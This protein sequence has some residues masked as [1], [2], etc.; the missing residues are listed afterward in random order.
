MNAMR[1]L[2][3][4]LI[5][6]FILFFLAVP[7]PEI[8]RNIK[9]LENIDLPW[10]IKVQEDQSTEV[11]KLKPGIS[12]LADAIARFHEPEEIAIYAGKQK[13]SLEAYL[14]TVN[15]GPLQAKMILTLAATDDELQTILERTPGLSL[16]SSG[17]KKLRLANEDIQ[18]ALQRPV[19]SITFIP[20]Y[21]GLDSDFF[22]ERLGEPFAWQRL[23]EEAVKYFY[24]KKGLSILIDGGGKEV[25]EYVH[26]ADFVLPDEVSFNET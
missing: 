3:F 5:V 19:T 16:S 26:P 15:L 22:K 24:P 4:S 9:D 23:G 17:D 1:F 20:K 21:S 11:F 25:L 7:E 14:G 10:N 12:T 13:R 6:L 8:G 18:Q 2:F